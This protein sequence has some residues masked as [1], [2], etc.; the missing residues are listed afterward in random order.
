MSV[1]VVIEH[2]QLTLKCD[3]CGHEWDFDD[4]DANSI[5]D[6]K[7]N[8]EDEECPQCKKNEGR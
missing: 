7:L 6:A 2:I 1:Q 3:E 5:D 4:F 8:A